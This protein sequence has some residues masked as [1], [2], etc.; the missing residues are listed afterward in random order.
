LIWVPA[1][2]VIHFDRDPKGEPQAED[3]TGPVLAAAT[4]TGTARRPVPH[5]M[6]QGC[7]VGLSFCDSRSQ[8]VRPTSDLGWAG[9]PVNIRGRAA[10]SEGDRSVSGNG[11]RAFQEGVKMIIDCDSCVVRNLACDDCVVTVMLGAPPGVLEV[12]CEEHSALLTLARSGLI[13]RLRMVPP[14][15]VAS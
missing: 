13:P 6:L 9:D 2:A 15:E 12:D 11:R 14:E 8:L 3:R 5:R 4:A 1:N 7:E 10:L